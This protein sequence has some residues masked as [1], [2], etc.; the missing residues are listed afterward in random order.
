M[1][2]QSGRIGSGII[3]A[4]YVFKIN[5]GCRVRPQDGR[6]E[7]NTRWCKWCMKCLCICLFLFQRNSRVLFANFE[8]FSILIIYENIS[9]DISGEKIFPV[10]SC[11]KIL[12]NKLLWVPWNFLFIWWYGCGWMHE[13]MNATIT[14]KDQASHTKQRS[15]ES[16]LYP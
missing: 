8:I 4:K 5:E 16:S 13:C 6:P 9:S 7:Q 14:L 10:F 3:P 2:H 11:L 12:A 15:W 1:I